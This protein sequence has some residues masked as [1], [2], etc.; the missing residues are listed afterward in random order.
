MTQGKV[1]KKTLVE[2][3]DERGMTET[4]KLLRCHRTAV[5]HW[6]RGFCL[7]S[8]EQMN[9]IIKYSNGAVSFDDEIRT[10]YKKAI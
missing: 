10:F 1:K 2:W 3:I 7:P 4:A 6:R 8:S 5:N 9:K